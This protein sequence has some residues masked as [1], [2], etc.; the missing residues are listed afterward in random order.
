MELAIYQV[1]ETGLKQAI[2]FYNWDIFSKERSIK[3]QRVFKTGRWTGLEIHEGTSLMAQRLTPCS[4]GRGHRFQPWLGNSAPSCHTVWP[5]KMKKNQ[6]RLSWGNKHL[7][8]GLKQS[9]KWVKWRKSTQGVW[10]PSRRR[11][12]GR[13]VWLIPRWWAENRPKMICRT[14]K[15]NDLAFKFF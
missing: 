12:W 13:T 11:L 2:Q 7:C 10:W 9:R 6:W 15:L 4:Q 14:L 3:W 1:G 5:P 8:W